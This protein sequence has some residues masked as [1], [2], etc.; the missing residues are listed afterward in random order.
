[1]RNKPFGELITLILN[2]LRNL[3]ILNGL[4]FL[5]KSVGSLILPG[6]LTLVPGSSQISNSIKIRI[7]YIQYAALGKFFRIEFQC[8]TYVQ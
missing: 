1:M 8:V 3:L 2:E 5:K 6:Y 7:K 4:F